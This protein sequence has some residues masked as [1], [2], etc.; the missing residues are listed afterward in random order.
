[1]RRFDY[2]QPHSL[3][4]AL[5]IMEEQT[6]EARYIAGG[7]DLIVRLKQGAMAVDA[8]VSLRGIPE[9]RGIAKNGEWRFGG[10]CLFREIE[11]SASVER[12]LPALFQ[13]VKVL[14]NPQLRNV[15]TIGGNLCNAAPSADCAPPLLVLDA[16][17]ALEG[18]GG[19]REVAIE[20]FFIGPGQTCKRPEE[21]MTGIRVP[22]P[23]GQTGSAFLKIG[24]VSQ[25]IAVV[26]MAVLVEMEGGVC[27]RCRLAAGAVAP[28]PLRLRRTEKR[29]EG[30]RIDPDLL[31]AAA[32]EAAEEVRPISDVRATAEYRCTVAGVLVKRGL[33]QALETVGR[34]D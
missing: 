22:Q 6:G 3:R 10:M 25:D 19:V 28:V 26:N 8:L 34:S 13:A 4:D 12:A 2:H 20:D 16:R 27:R 32:A 11:R 31:E 1:M 29:I 5:K 23:G 7:T 9:L 30:R 17:I 24:R 18:P 14:A 15:A 33:Q 21:V